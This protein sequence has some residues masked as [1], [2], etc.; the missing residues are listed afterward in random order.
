MLIEAVVSEEPAVLS[1]NCNHILNNIVFSVYLFLNKNMLMDLFI[2]FND[3]QYSN[4]K[5]KLFYMIINKLVYLNNNILQNEKFKLVIK[6]KLTSICKS[7][8]TDR[9]GNYKINYFH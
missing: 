6:D 2:G 4:Y 3:N 8:S 1:F 5:C 9:Y 7:K